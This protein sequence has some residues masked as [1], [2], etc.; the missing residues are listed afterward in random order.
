MGVYNRGVNNI[1]TATSRD[2]VSFEMDSVYARDYTIKRNEAA[3]SQERGSIYA[4]TSITFLDRRAM[5]W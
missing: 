2:G 3:G 1:Y 5:M 4:S